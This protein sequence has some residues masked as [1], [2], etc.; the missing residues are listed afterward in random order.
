MLTIKQRQTFNLIRRNN[1]CS[2]HINCIRLSPANSWIHEKKKIEI[3]WFLLKNNMKF[4]TE[5]IFDDSK[6]RADILVLD[7]GVVY[8]VLHTESLDQ[9]KKKDQHLPSYSRN[10]I[11]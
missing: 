1:R 5:A 2:S 3:C 4:V 8:E 11:H 6:G 9:A 7:N 10:K